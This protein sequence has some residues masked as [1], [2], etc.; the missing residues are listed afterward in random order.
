LSR[1][2]PPAV[3]AVR[4]PPS[5]D[6]GFGE[7]RKADTPTDTVRLKADTTTDAVGLP[8]SPGGSGATG[9]ADT[10]AGAT[11]LRP[12]ALNNVGTRAIRVMRDARERWPRDPEVYEALG[13]SQIWRGA[14]DDAIA[15]FQQAVALVPNE[16]LGYFNLG[17]AYE[18]KYRNSRRYV[19]QLR[20]WYSDAT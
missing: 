17:K 1:T 16:G 11:R 18:L 3:D 20:T 4:L 6:N 5:P 15:S 12:D 10:T 9:K 13:V 14:Y 8:P 19:Q 7:S 2:L